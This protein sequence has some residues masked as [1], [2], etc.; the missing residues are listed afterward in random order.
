MH[1][2]TTPV[3]DEISKLD[4]TG[5]IIPHVWY[6]KLK[7]PFRGKEI[8]YLE[9]IIILSDIIYW[10]RHTE[11]RHKQT[12]AYMGVSRKFKSDKLQKK[13][14]EL[15]SQFGLS[16]EEVKSAIKFLIEKN[17]ITREFRT[18]TCGSM[19]LNNVM[20]LEPVPESIKILNTPTCTNITESDEF[21]EDFCDSYVEGIPLPPEPGYTLSPEPGYTLSPETTPPLPPEPGETNTDITTENTTKK[22]PPPYGRDSRPDILERNSIL[23]DTKKELINNILDT[24][25]TKNTLSNNKSN[26]LLDNNSLSN[27]YKKEKEE[28][29]GTFFVAPSLDEV[30]L[31]CKENSYSDRVGIRFFDKMTISMWKL[32][33]GSPV[34]SWR[35]LLESWAAR[36]YLENKKVK[37]QMSLD[38]AG[39]AYKKR[40]RG[41][42]SNLKITYYINYADDSQYDI[43]QEENAKDL[44]AYGGVC[45]LCGEESLY[46]EQDAKGLPHCNH[47]GALFLIDKNITHTQLV[48]ASH[49]R[50]VLASEV[51][52]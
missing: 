7:R 44:S 39:E 34:V 35:K 28:K 33:D 14:S 49:I 52:N 4:F 10:Y 3:V 12:G 48:N 37:T 8:P 24:I 43:S 2:P 18:I 38:N 47:C 9:A 30:L 27:N 29:K 6:L 50:S 31:A 26:N 11:I 5:N 16:V 23:R 15:A 36:E 17:L 40:N 20:Y 25:N 19:V 42:T 45:E 1:Y 51:F 41:K 21:D 46:P 22:N 13:Y 32:P